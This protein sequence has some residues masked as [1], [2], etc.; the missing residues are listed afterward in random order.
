MIDGEMLRIVVRLYSQRVRAPIYEGDIVGYAD[1]YNEA[2]E[3]VDSIPL[4]ASE[5]VLRNT[6]GQ[7]LKNLFDGLFTNSAS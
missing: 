5:T 7:R 3:L 6:F 4:K 2:N 1:V